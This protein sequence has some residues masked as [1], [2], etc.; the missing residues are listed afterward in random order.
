[1]TAVEAFIDSGGA[2]LWLNCQVGYQYYLQQNLK[3][4]R[5]YVDCD[6]RHGNTFGD[7]IVGFGQELP[8]WD[9]T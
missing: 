3:T 8:G 1:M 2:W 9:M 5:V 7:T 6:I 4:G